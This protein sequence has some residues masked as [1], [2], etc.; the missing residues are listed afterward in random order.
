ML[1]FALKYRNAGLCPIPIWP[2]ERKNPHLSSTTLYTQRLPTIKEIRRWWD[3]WPRANIGLITG[4]WRNLVALDFDSVDDYNAWN[5]LKGQTWT[6][7]TA[8]G[9]HV[10][11]ELACTP[12]KSENWEDGQGHNVLVRA[13]GGYCISPPSMHH[14]GAKYTTVHNVPPLLVD[15]LQTALD[16]WKPKH[17]L[18][19]Q[20][21]IKT[22]VVSPD[23]L[24]IEDLV[25]IPEWSRPQGSYGA[26]KVFCPFAEN[27]QGGKDNKP[28]AWL[29]IE[30]QRVGCNTCGEWWD[31]VNIYAKINGLTNGE[32]YKLLKG[33]MQQPI[34]G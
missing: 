8:R 23:A 34:D 17:V 25:P 31:V 30:Q 33:R 16:G 3:R 21:A 15:D 22:P 1:T 5:V 11:F 12:G 19:P 4:Y 20:K 29:N 9:C 18:K 14:T 28:S 2:D 7:A 24:R 6:V 27:H 10:W 13:K 32:A 26:Y